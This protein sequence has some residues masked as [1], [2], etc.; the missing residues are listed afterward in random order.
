VDGPGSAATA[1]QAS[2]NAGS[3]AITCPMISLMRRLDPPLPLVG[4]AFSGRPRRGRSQAKRLGSAAEPVYD[5][6]GYL[7][8]WRAMTMRWIW[9]VPS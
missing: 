6:A 5:G 8:S 7:R 1:T 4:K 9:L 3:T 2:K